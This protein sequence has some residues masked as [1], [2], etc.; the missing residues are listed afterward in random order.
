MIAWIERTMDE[1][2][3]TQCYT[4]IV[5]SFFFRWI[6]VSNYVCNTLKVCVTPSR[7]VSKM[8]SDA[9]DAVVSYVVL[10]LHCC[11]CSCFIYLAF[12]F[13]L[14]NWRG[15]RCVSV[16]A[17]VFIAWARALF[18]NARA[19]MFLCFFFYSLHFAIV[20]LLNKCSFVSYDICT[21]WF[22][23]DAFATAHTAFSQRSRWNDSNSCFVILG[24]FFVFFSLSISLDLFFFFPGVCTICAVSLLLLLW[25]L[26]RICVSRLTRSHTT[27]PHRL[28]FV[29]VVSAQGNSINKT[30]T[31]TTTKIVISI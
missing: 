30:P 20:N 28:Y 13:D 16:S 1:L 6:S 22:N 8:C 2:I 31:T 14:V 23:C 15:E 21:W 24:C 11:C 27:L 10:L 4:F 19:S 25:L 29:F 18:L 26:F 9:A 12:G 5:S 7:L 3:H 17:S